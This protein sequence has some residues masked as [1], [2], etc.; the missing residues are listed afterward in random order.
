MYLDIEP[1]L[2]QALLRGAW[3]AAAW[4]IVDPRE[5]HAI[6]VLSHNIGSPRRHVEAARRRR[7]QRVDARRN[8]GLAVVDGLR[9]LLADRVPGI[10]VSSL[11]S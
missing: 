6:R 7:W 9:Y 3:L 11:R 4:D 5:E 1:G 2:A 10:G 8:A